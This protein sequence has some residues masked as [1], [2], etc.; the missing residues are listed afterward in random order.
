MNSFF[1]TC[2]FI[3]WTL[4]WSFASVII[5]RLKSWEKWIWTWRSHCNKCNHILWFLDLVPLFSYISNKWK[6]KYCKDKVSSIYPIL[7]ITTWLLY[8]LIWYFL[9]D[10]NLILS[11]SW[12]E[13]TK[14]LF[15]LTIWFLSIVYTFYDI[16]FLE[17]HDYVLW[18]GVVLS[19]LVLSLQSIFPSFQV[20]EWLPIMTQ[21][22]SIGIYASI[23]SLI[24][25]AWLYVIMLK[26]IKEIYDIII[27][28]SSIIALYI[29]KIIFSIDL[30]DIPILSW[31]VWALWI[32]IFFFL[33]HLLWLILHAIEKKK[34]KKKDY[35]FEDWVIWWWDLRIAI[36]IWLI[37]WIPFSF[38]WAM[39]SYLV[40]TII[41]ISLILYSK[42]KHKK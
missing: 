16:L 26:W 5:Y 13:I 25:V 15:F 3:F 37:L 14:L 2:L 20:I 38:A 1:Y 33:Q 17:I 42:I 28:I 23:I 36:L 34:K 4:F 35:R 22:A 12:L 21:P 9:L 32:F 39:V 6:C 27:I 11:W 40:W 24:I 18:L 29:F 30:S 41:S 19:L 10:F 31:I 7:E 8:A